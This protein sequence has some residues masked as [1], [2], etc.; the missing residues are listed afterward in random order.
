MW[1]VFRTSVMGM[2]LQNMMRNRR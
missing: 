2:L 1:F